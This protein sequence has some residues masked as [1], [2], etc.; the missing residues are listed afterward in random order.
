MA[1]N[2]GIIIMKDVYVNTKI[3]L[4]TNI[5]NHIFSQQINDGARILALLKKF[6]NNL[7]IPYTV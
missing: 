2:E 5:L 1:Y 3:I 4:D 6:K 7:W